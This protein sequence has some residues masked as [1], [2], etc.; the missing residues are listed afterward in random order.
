V[1]F[2]L[3]YQFLVNWLGYQPGWFTSPRSHRPRFGVSASHKL[4]KRIAH[5]FHRR[6]WWLRAHKRKKSFAASNWS[7]SAINFPIR[8]FVCADR[9]FGNVTLECARVQVHDARSSSCVYR[10]FHPAVSRQMSHCHFPVAFLTQAPVPFR[11]SLISMAFVADG[12]CGM[13]SLDYTLR[14][15]RRGKAARYK[16]SSKVRS[17][18]PWCNA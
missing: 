4:V 12:I 3:A 6:D 10:K 16:R 1:L 17:R 13:Q 8:A 9:V 15:A 18:N 11:M 7:R 2:L 14:I 5:S